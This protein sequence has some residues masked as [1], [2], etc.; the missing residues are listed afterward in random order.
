[1]MILEYDEK[2]RIIRIGALSQSSVHIQAMRLAMSAL[3]HVARDFPGANWM[4]WMGCR[5]N[6][7][8]SP[9][10]EIVPLTRDS[11]KH[12]WRQQRNV[13]GM[14][15]LDARGSCTLEPDVSAGWWT[16]RSLVS[17]QSLPLVGRWSK[18]CG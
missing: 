2:I 11:P 4:G 17:Y 13:C 15:G 14:Q 12:A 10:S 1:M 6:H 9:G 5:M 16:S 7:D 3:Y 8:G 18:K